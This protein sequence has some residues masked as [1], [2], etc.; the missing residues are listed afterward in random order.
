MGSGSKSI[1]WYWEIDYE[2]ETYRDFKAID[3]AEGEVAYREK[4]D[5]KVDN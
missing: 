4:F 5:L 2:L 1:F 3:L